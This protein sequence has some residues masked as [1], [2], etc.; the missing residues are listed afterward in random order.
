MR[1]ASCIRQ[2]RQ[3][4]LL[5]EEIMANCVYQQI[6]IIRHPYIFNQSD[7]KEYAVR[8]C[9]TWGALRLCQVLRRQDPPLRMCPLNSSANSNFSSSLHHCTPQLL[10]PFAR[11]EIEDHRSVSRS[12]EAQWY[13]TDEQHNQISGLLDTKKVRDHF[14]F[15]SQHPSRMKLLHYSQT[16]SESLCW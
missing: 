15:P 13:M 14:S 4:F 12:G 16:C 7:K 1:K 5:L 3:Q 8:M 6:L 9:R 2:Q 10:M 11:L